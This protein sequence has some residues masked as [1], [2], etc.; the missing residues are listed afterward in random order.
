MSDGSVIQAIEST[1]A[2][3]SLIACLC[4]G[5]KIRREGTSNIANKMLSFLFVLDFI[6]ALAYVVGRAA[7]PIDGF[8]Q[9]Q[10]LII[11]WFSLAA[12]FWVVLMAYQMRQWIVA[13]K[14]PKRIEASMRNSMLF[15]LI[16]TGIMGVAL[17]GA[18]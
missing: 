4:M 16:S 8:C 9:F 2:A 7:M 1:C 6:L 18:G 13:K 11:Q 14:N 12:I 17:W 10:G 5:I 3:V 15:I